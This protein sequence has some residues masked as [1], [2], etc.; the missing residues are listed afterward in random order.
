MPQ[1][2]RIYESE[3]AKQRK[4]ESRKIDDRCKGL[5]DRF[6]ANSSRIPSSISK[7]NV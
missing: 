3:A 6:V 2:N 7:F 5:M 4:E 1:L